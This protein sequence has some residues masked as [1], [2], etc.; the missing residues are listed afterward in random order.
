MLLATA[1]FG[2]VRHRP[3]AAAYA[4]IVV[5]L[6]VGYA[7][8]GARVRRRVGPIVLIQAVTSALV[9]LLSVLTA[10]SLGVAGIRLAYLTAQVVVAAATLPAL[11]R[12]L[13]STP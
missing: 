7:V 4:Y 6:L 11:M 12:L 1:G 13:R 5:L 9:V 3:R 2:W 10:R 8:F